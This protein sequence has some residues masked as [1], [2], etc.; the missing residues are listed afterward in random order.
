MHVTFLSGSTVIGTAFLTPFDPPM[1]VAG[2]AFEPT[3]H[4][5]RHDHANVVEGEFV[6]YLGLLLSANSDEHGPIPCEWIAIHDFGE[7]TGEIEITICVG[8]PEYESY[9]SEYAG[10]KTYFGHS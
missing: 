8:H 1:G 9:F 3:E 5:S 6:D 10:F 2:G 4:Y 7:G